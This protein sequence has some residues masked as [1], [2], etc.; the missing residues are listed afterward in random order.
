LYSL[1]RVL[2]VRREHTQRI[3]RKHQA[4]HLL[5]L[6]D[7]QSNSTDQ[8]Q[9]ARELNDKARLRHPAWN[10]QN[11]A[12]GCCEVSNAGRTVERCKN[13]P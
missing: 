1:E 2:D 4:S 12:I 7:Q 3:Q 10:N 8:L 13:P 11:E 5:E 6:W 9:G